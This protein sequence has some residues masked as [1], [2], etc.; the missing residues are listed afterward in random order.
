MLESLAVRF[1]DILGSL[2][3]ESI[4]ALESLAKHFFDQAGPGAGFAEQRC[5]ACVS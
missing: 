2:E 3:A 1:F 5:A 4:D